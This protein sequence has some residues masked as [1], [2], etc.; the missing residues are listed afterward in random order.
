[1]S[2]RSFYNKEV[3]KLVKYGYLYNWYVTQGTGDNSIIPLAMANAGWKLPLLEMTSIQ[4]YLGGSSVAGGKLK[5]IGETYW[6]SNVGATNNV[7]FNSRG[8]GYR[9]GDGS[10]GGFRLNHRIWNTYA[11][12]G[13]PDYGFYLLIQNATTASSYGS[14]GKKDGNSIRLVRPLQ[15]GEQTIP[16]GQPVGTYT[17]NDGLVYPTVRIGSE[18]WLA[19][20]LAETMLRNG[21]LIPVITDNTQWANL[22]TGAMCYQQN[23]INNVFI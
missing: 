18:V 22:T 14:C 11:D 9:Q 21:T 12:S 16:D 19:C 17:G 13:M 10:F 3:S 5:E 15:L 8:G 20:N 23:D 4:S 6:Q 1:M 2:R 7:N